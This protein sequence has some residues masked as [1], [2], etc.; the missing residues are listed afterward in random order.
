MNIG[1]LIFD[2]VEVLDFCGPLETFSVINDVSDIA[3]NV[4]TIAKK[5][6]IIK[7]KSNLN[8]EPNHDFSSHPTLDILIIPGG[9]GTRKLLN[10][11]ETLKWIYMQHMD[12]K[13]L[14]SVCTGSLVLAK[15]GLL[16]EKKATTHHT[17]YH[18]LEEIDPTIT[19]IKDQRFVDE[20]N[21]LTSGG[22]SAGIDLS[23]HMIE[24]IWDKDLS[25]QVANEMEYDIY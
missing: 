15:L 22:I 7:A 8:V 25:Q 14:M 4:I 13:Y 17:C 21:I 23:F 24:K 6:T 11:E 12:V 3:V 10:D 9:F 16:L 19:I 5:K 18:L 2:D 20:G 1:I